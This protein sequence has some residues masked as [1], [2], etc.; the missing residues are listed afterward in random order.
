[1]GADLAESML[2]EADTIAAISRF[3]AEAEKVRLASYLHNVNA[4]NLAMS[5]FAAG[6][7]YVDND[8]ISHIVETPQQLQRYNWNDFIARTKLSA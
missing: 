5:A 6:V 1:V 7:R 2:S 4:S 8:T 3:A